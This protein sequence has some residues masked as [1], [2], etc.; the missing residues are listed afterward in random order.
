MP[1][2]EDEKMTKAKNNLCKILPVAIM[3]H[4]EEK[5]ITKAINSIL[6]QI[7]PAG[8]SVKVIVVA[9]ACTDNTED[10]V[11]RLGEHNLNKV[12]L[13]S[14]KKKGKTIAIKEAIKLFEKLSN[15]SVKLP[16]VI[17]LDAD[18]E[19]I[20]REALVNFIKK[21]EDNSALCA[22]AAQCVPDVCFN[23]RQDIVAGTYR[24]VNALRQSIRINS[25][26]GM[27]YAIRFNILKKIDFPEFQLNEDMYLS[28]RLNGHFLRDSTI[29]IVFQTPRNCHNEL[30]RRIRQEIY[31]QRYREYYSHLKKREIPVELFEKPL[32]DDYRWGTVSNDNFFKAWLALQGLKL[33]FYAILYLLIRLLAKL[34]AQRKVKLRIHLIVK[35]FDLI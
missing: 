1:R 32:G 9:N 31:S 35:K 10:V 22:I 20:G 18:C 34:K 14:T 5:V 3:A 8:Y 19:F 2:I 15:T 13:I 7:T 28:S 4:N 23:S 6:S 11:N 21:F 16:Y 27:C 33:K 12:Q 30:T 29:S 26:S 17:F 25:I 24:A